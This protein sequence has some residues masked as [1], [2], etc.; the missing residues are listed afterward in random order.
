MGG[1]S[2]QMVV[3]NTE[4][5][6]TGCTQYTPGEESQAHSPLVVRKLINLLVEVKTESG[7]GLPGLCQS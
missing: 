4:A 7:S 5:A 1:D 6:T 2:P 3:D